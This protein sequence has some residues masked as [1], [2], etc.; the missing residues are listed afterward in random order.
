MMTRLHTVMGRFRTVVG[1]ILMAMALLGARPVHAISQWQGDVS[2]A[3]EAAG[4]WES[5]NLPDTSWHATQ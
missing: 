3:W 4:N 5:G 1:L 2:S